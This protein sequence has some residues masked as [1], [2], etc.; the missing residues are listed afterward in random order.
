[1]IAKTASGVQWLLS[2]IFQPFQ[3]GENGLSIILAPWILSCCSLL[4]FAR[5]LKIRR[6][7]GKPPYIDES[8][9]AGSNRVGLHI[10][11]LVFPSMPTGRIYVV[12]SPDL[13]ASIERHPLKIA[14]RQV[15]ALFSGRSVGPSPFAAKIL[16]TNIQ[17]E[18]KHG[19]FLRDSVS[20]VHATLKPGGKLMETT[21]AMA[22]LL[23]PAIKELGE[24]GSG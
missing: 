16:A 6:Y 21:R 15:E 18:E 11:T 1:M 10:Y 9:D 23:V 3:S 4:L 22:K 7:M 14:F 17:S 5:L 19:S 12:N 13:A 24:G 20:N 8:F 2:E